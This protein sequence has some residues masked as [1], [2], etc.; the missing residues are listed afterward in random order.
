MAVLSDLAAE[1]AYCSEELPEQCVD[2]V[3]LEGGESAHVIPREIP[4][5]VFL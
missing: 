4:A 5:P 2:L 1:A 3:C